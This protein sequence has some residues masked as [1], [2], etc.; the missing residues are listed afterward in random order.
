MNYIIGPKMDKNGMF[1]GNKFTRDIV[2][3]FN[4]LGDP[5]SIK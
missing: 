4:E 1:A 3:T 5:L 2:N